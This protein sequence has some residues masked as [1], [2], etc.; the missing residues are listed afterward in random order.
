MKKLFAVLLAAALLFTFAACGAESADVPDTSAATEQIP[1]P[2]KAAEETS[3]ASGDFALIGEIKTQLVGDWKYSA[4][5][6]VKLTF[7]D[8]GTGSYLGLD[9]AERSFLYF[10]T[11]SHETYANGAEYINNVLK[12]AY[13]NGTSEEIAVDFPEEGGTKLILH[14]L[15]ENGYTGGYSG[16]IDFDEWTKE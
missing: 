12:V 2:T 7:R 16:V 4:Y 10:V 9:G 6:G 8:N 14:S 1:A 15:E 13:N 3:A 5:D 11:V